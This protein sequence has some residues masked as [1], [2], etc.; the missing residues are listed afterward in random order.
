MAGALSKPCGTLF[1]WTLDEL[2]V[3]I[4]ICVDHVLN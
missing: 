4:M 2:T 1:V 3:I